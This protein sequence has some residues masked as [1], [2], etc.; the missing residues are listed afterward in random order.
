MRAAVAFGCGLLFA[1]GLGVA[2]MTQPSR[3]IGF[4]DVFNAWDPTLLF[5]MAGAIVVYLP[6][7]WLV[8]GR[9]AWLGGGAISRASRHDLDGRLFTG[10]ALFGIGWGLSGICPGPGI[11]LLARPDTGLVV[12][13]AA[14]LAGMAL[15]AGYERTRL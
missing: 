8:R 9:R 10:A 3:I 12:F 5:V 14:T 11:V 6:A 7:W 4:L 2:Q 13:V 1:A 15:K